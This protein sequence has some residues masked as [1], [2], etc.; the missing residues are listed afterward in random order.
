MSAID[1]KFV[2]KANTPTWFVVVAALVK[3]NIGGEWT[4]KFPVIVL[5]TQLP[6]VT[7]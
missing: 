4:V 5:L 6:P 3:F 2:H 1:S 7:I